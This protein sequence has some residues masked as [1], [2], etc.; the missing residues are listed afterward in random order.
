MKY[1][2]KWPRTPRTPGGFA[3]VNSA[4]GVKRALSQHTISQ[5]KRLRGHVEG[6]AIAKKNK[7]KKKRSFVSCGLNM[8]WEGE[9]GNSIP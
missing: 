6:C 9:S 1:R 5:A 2:L 4:E 7:Q 8:G 3:I